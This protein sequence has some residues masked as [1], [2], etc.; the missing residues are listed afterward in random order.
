MGEV[1]IIKQ[2]LPS[3]FF[4]P[5][6]HRLLPAA[7]RLPRLL[8]SP[9]TLIFMSSRN[10]F[11][12]FRRTSFTSTTTPQLV[13]AGEV[14]KYREE[15][16]LTELHPDLLISEDLP[17]FFD[18]PTTTNATQS[19]SDSDAV[20]VK[21]R[22]TSSRAK[23]SVF[24]I[25]SH[26]LNGT[27]VP[28]KEPSF[29]HLPASY[30]HDNLNE[31]LSAIGYH[32]N[33]GKLVS[34]D[35]GPY[36]RHIPRD[37][38][39][40]EFIPDE[41]NNANIQNS[42]LPGFSECTRAEYDMDRTDNEF[43]KS[44]NKRRRQGARQPAVSKEVFET[45]MTLLELAWFWVEQRMPPRTKFKVTDEIPDAEDQ[46]CVICDDGECDNNNV[47][48]F[49]DGCDIAVHQ[50]CYGVPFI[51]EGQWLCKA[52]QASRTKLLNCLF[53]PNRSGVFKKTDTGEWV[54]LICSIWLPEVSIPN[55]I[56]VEPVTGVEEIDRNRW[57]LVCFICKQKMGACIQCSNKK[58]S[59]AYHP[60]CGRKARLYM[61]MTA[62]IHGALVDQS[63]VI[64]FCDKHTPIDFKP[65]VSV[66]RTVEIAKAYYRQRGPLA[67]TKHSP[68]NYNNSQ[69]R[70]TQ[71]EPPSGGDW[72]TKRGIPVIPAFIADRIVKAL[73]KF[74]ITQ[75]TE[76]VNE[77][78]RYWVLKKEHLKGAYL[79]KRLQNCVP[80]ESFPLTSARG[81]ITEEASAALKA[82]AEE[83]E[84]QLRFLD[85]L[86]SQ[87]ERLREAETRKLELAEVYERL[88]IAQL[89]PFMDAIRF[90]WAKVCELDHKLVQSFNSGDKL[91]STTMSSISTVSTTQGETDHLLKPQT[92]PKKVI[93]TLTGSARGKEISKKIEGF[94]Y[95]TLEKFRIDVTSLFDPPHITRFTYISADS[96][97]GAKLIIARLISRAE[98]DC[99]LETE[100]YMPEFRVL[101]P[102]TRLSQPSSPPPSQPQQQ[103][104]PSKS[105]PQAELQLQREPTTVPYESSKRK[106]KNQYSYKDSTLRKKRKEKEPSLLLPELLPQKTLKSNS[107][108][109]FVADNSG[110][111][112]EGIMQQGVDED[113]CHEL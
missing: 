42:A 104:R 89:Y 73:A 74:E 87:A 33:A 96:A 48:V 103:K 37:Q 76:F 60:T 56:F 2:P 59:Q 62:G 18:E 17:V 100:R 90:I 8:P 68:N 79:L 95:Y 43:F 66:K 92:A 57:R 106:H 52:C 108:S 36:Y 98:R 93:T 13:E 29:L 45:T 10:R 24:N 5:A 20:V 54:H 1:L 64:S 4:L 65:K 46:K 49:C 110:N 83:L 34:H 28:T 9:L 38:H 72:K 61:K 3:V 19:E 58:C 81:P 27:V 63:T 53:C 111:S 11:G 35:A 50:D 12:L 16:L 7:N 30:T 94:E 14:H 80:L 75:C 44:L 39:V 97:A 109:A 82:R 113:S 69:K 86:R 21:S 15:R 55:N 6:A 22:K 77:L 32:H 47:I 51:P 91:H 40:E 101:L 71:G 70:I 26:D 23:F 105:G 107:E 85:Q 67:W 41:Y 102:D 31:Y 88:V 99:A 84:A 78:C 112:N 25:P